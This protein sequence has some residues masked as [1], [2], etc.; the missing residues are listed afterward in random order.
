MTEKA[1]KMRGFLTKV[2]L[3]IDGT[4]NQFDKETLEKMVEA[5]DSLENILRCE[6][7]V[8]TSVFVISVA[9]DDLN[10]LTTNK[11]TIQSAMKLKDLY[12]EP[13]CFN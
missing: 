8:L 10:R 12:L 5:C 3:T 6:L 7:M 2:E 1:L 9:K 4:Y 13:F 11:Q